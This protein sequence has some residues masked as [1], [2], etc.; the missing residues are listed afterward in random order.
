[1]TDSS[2]PVVLITGA[3]S[4]IGAAT[5]RKFASEGWNIVALARRAERLEGLAKEL[6]G[7]AKV[8][9]VA[10][11][12]TSDDAPK[13]AVEAAMS[14]FGR[15]DCMVNNAGAFEFGSVVEITDEALDKAIDISFKAPFRFSREAL[16]VMKPGSSIVSI[17]SVWGILAGMGGGAYCAL[18]AAL[19]GLTQSIA[20]DF[21]AKGI[22][23]NVVA[24][25]VV[26]TEMTDAFW[27]AEPFRRTNH[28]LTP[29]DREATV[30]DV[31]NAV[32]F[33]ASPA[34]SFINGQTIALDGG[35]STTK[36]LAVEAIMAERVKK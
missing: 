23:A 17:G 26:K 4:G 5:A 16:G 31:A 3:S 18:K 24:P 32:F 35:W 12:V 30:D 15:L 9:V 10:A 6:E 1:M 11:D 33:M 14:T 19:I 34:G 20:A 7:T 36:Y 22:R 27:D 21:G 29:I 13:K 28:E 25:G 8:A 2:K